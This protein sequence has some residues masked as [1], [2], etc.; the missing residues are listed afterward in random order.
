[1]KTA[2]DL[3]GSKFGRLT[4]LERAQNENKQVMWKCI[5]ED[6]NQVTV[7]AQ[8]LRE[9]RI[10]SCGCLA[11]QMTSARSTTHGKTQTVEHKAWSAMR[12]RCN[13]ENNKEYH[14]YGGRGICVCAEWQHSFEHF[15]EDMGTRPFDKYSIGR[16]DNNGNYEKSNCRWENRLEQANNK[17]NSL[18]LELDGTR[19]TQAQWSKRV[20]IGA[21]TLAMRLRYGWSI[22]RA[23]TEPVNSTI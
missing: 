13:N 9:G 2:K 19:L 23:L 20:G 6:G 17:A 8:H 22:R 10:Q 11:R 14:S 21:G 5:C 15:L 16:I 1:M 4:V 3:T 7:R 12:D 18:F